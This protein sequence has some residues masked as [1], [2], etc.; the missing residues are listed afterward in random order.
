[1]R[2]IVG[3]SGGSGIIYGVRLLEALK[4]TRVESHLIMT[5]AAKET[6]VLETDF[7]VGEVESLATVSYR[8]NDIA[9]GPSSGSYK[10]DGMAV[11]PCSMKSLAGIAVGYEDNLL[12]RAAA[13]TLKERRKLVLVPRETPL[14]IIQIENL[15]AVSRAGAVV[16]PAMPGFYHRPKTLDDLV[17]QLV[18]KVLD[19]FDIE[20]D[21]FR[22]WDGPDRKKGS[23][24]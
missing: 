24:R 4:R 16:L 9:A 22:R 6:L 13:V 10:T 12:L 7:S 19:A 15:L 3:I 5:Q 8:V 23:K 18:G 11:V 1:L 14:T 2:I 20:N 21:L 17:N